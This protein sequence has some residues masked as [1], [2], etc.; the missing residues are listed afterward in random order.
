MNMVRPGGWF[1]PDQDGRTCWPNVSRSCKT[2]VLS[3]RACKPMK[4]E[5]RK[6]RRWGEMIRRRR[7]RARIA[8][9]F[10]WVLRQPK[11]RQSNVHSAGLPRPAARQTLGYVQ[12][13]GGTIGRRV[14]YFRTQ[15]RAGNGR[16]RKRATWVWVREWQVNLNRAA[17]RVFLFR[18]PL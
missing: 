17:G 11:S 2:P 15:S 3:P 10:H 14:A 18:R 8:G 6:E 12:S 13:N 9:S 1:G 5:N 7:T 4:K 16:S